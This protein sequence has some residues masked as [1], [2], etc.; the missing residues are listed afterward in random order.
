MRVLSEI[1]NFLYQCKR[2]LMVA[3]KPDK[4]EFKISTK[5]VL[6]GMALLG[7]IAFIIFIIFQFISWL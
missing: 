4:E 3:A 5:I 6:L 7:A 1:K 2:V